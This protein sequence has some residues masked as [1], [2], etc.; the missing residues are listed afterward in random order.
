M[1]IRKALLIIQL[2]LVS[3]NVFAQNPNPSVILDNFIT[4][5]MIELNIPGASTVGIK[6][7]EIVWLKSYGYADIDN[8]ILVTDD[9][10]FM[11]ASTSKLITCTALMKLYDSGLFDLDDD[12]NSYLPFQIINPNY[13]TDIITFRMLLTHSSSLRDNWTVLSTYY[14]DGD[15]PTSLAQVISNY[16]NVLGSDYDSANNFYN[17]APDVAYNYCNMA[18]ALCGYLVEILSGMSF[19]QYCKANIF[20]E[21]CMTNTSWFLS[22]L[23]INNVAKP[24][25]WTGFGYSAY[26]H[27]GY[28]DYP[29]GQ[30]R[31]SIN[32]LSNFLITYIQNGE[33]D[34]GQLLS[35]S[36]VTEILSPQRVEWWGGQ[37]L[38]WYNE[39][40]YSSTGGNYDMFWGHG[41]ND[42][43]VFSE[44]H[45]DVN[46][47][48]GVALI[49]NGEA[50]NMDIIYE[51]YDY[52]KTLGEN[53]NGT[54]TCATL[55]IDEYQE[56]EFDIQLY[57]NPTKDNL[58]IGS[59]E[60]IEKVEVYNYI[61]Q[62]VLESTQLQI[63]TI[64]FNS[65]M[66]LLKIYGV[67]GEVGIKKFVKK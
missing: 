7:G 25:E 1:Y 49:T 42:S 54:T 4:N 63:N 41:G 31:T 34:A 9:T 18:I 47:S 32:D 67:N 65:G 51:I 61:G 40:S 43:G 20:E 38:V 12:I 19:D 30:L 44:L 2:L 36:T 10:S 64:N 50:E 11:V 37:G 59:H 53:P 26:N 21:L 8:N 58:Y 16:F 48:I 3:F 57:P 22:G 52:V 17:Y 15:H 29:D 14:V 6:N 35:N 23:D 60:P 45:I 56:K 66:Y 28:P 33:Y 13:P 24:Y 62:K 46:E 5:K 39:P 27:Y 55:A